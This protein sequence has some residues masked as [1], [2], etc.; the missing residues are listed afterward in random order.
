MFF[1]T[2]I[3]VMIGSFADSVVVLLAAAG[4]LVLVLAEAVAVAVALALALALLR[5]LAGLLSEFFAKGSGALVAV[6]IGAFR[7]L[8]LVDCGIRSAVGASPSS[9]AMVKGKLLRS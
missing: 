7:A 5:P 3:G 9:L 6:V 4:A 2:V 8:V 1:K